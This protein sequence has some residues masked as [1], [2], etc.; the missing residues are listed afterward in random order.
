MLSCVTALTS[1]FCCVLVRWQ[2]LEWGS[3]AAMT[4]VALV[5]TLQL[6]FAV[7]LFFKGPGRHARVLSIST[8]R[9]PS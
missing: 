2:A 6:G 7:I 9:T 1:A 8:G 3:T 5:I 4:Q